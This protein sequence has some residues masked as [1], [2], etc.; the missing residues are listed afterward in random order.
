MH[1]GRRQEQGK[2]AVIGN[3]QSR[4][5]FQRRDHQPVIDNFQRG[6]MRRGRQPGLH[7]GGIALLEAER[8]VVGGLV[9][10]QRH[11]GGKRGRTVHNRRQR[12]VVHHNPF[13]GVPRIG[14]G[15]G[16]DK[17][18]GIA[19]MAHAAIGQSRARRHDHR[20]HSRNGRRAG[21]QAEMG[22]IRVCIHRQHAG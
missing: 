4:A 16:D 18:H 12:P 9:P 11:I 6:D 5:G 22:D 17:G 19:G 2:Q 3:G 7:G 1:A 15:F 10:Q 21:Q 8:L 13:G 14:Q 20:L